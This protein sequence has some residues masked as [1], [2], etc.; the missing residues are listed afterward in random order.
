MS[1]EVQF[2]VYDG[3]PQS[4]T[5]AQTLST[6]SCTLLETDENKGLSLRLRKNGEKLSKLRKRASDFC[7]L[8]ILGEGAY[9]TV[10]LA[11][12]LN[13]GQTQAIKVVQ[14]DFVI[15]H[16]KLAATV[17]EKHVLASLTYERGG[18]PFVT[19]LYCT[20][21]DPERLYF[22][23]DVA[24]HG[25]LMVALNRLGSFDVC[26]CQFYAAE[27][28]AAL[29]FIHKYGVVHRDVKPDNIL[30]RKNGHIMLTDFGSAQVYDESL[31]VDYLEENDS[32]FQIRNLRQFR[33]LTEMPTS[34]N[35]SSSIESDEQLIGSE[36]TRRA[37][38]V[39][40]AQYVSPEMLRGDEVGPPCDYWALGAIVF[41]MISGLA[42]F[43]AINDFHLMNKIQKLDFTFPPNFPDI[44]KDFVS[45]LLVLDPA[46]RLGSSNLNEL[47][48][49]EFFSGIKW[50]HVTDM[51][52]PNISLSVSAG[53]VEAEAT[54]TNA[55][56]PGLNERALNRLMNL[57]LMEVEPSKQPSL[58]SEILNV[59]VDIPSDMVELF[60]MD[61]KAMA[62]R[63]RKLEKQ[64]K[65]NPYHLFVQDN[66]I[67][68]SG[69]IDKK[70]GLFSRRRMFLL[71]EGPHLFY[72]DPNN[73]ELKGEVPW[74][75]CMRTEVKNFRSF[76]VHTPKRIY[77]LFDPESRAVE[78]CKAI[79]QV[80]LR[81]A[82]K[83]AESYARAIKDG[84]FG[85]NKFKKSSN[86]FG[87]KR[88]KSGESDKNGE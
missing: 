41:Q 13:G 22:V 70:K 38:F 26:V 4:S 20:F 66:L 12:E 84:T 76:F 61:K 11:K 86:Y 47:K 71:T 27:I 64:R 72:V 15:R 52:P 17:R 16:Q 8:R 29:E 36:S 39:G 78:W 85:M 68:R 49:H 3:D 30:L 25:E 51:K 34:S 46:T 48:C 5:E 50:E 54:T 58:S 79:E 73:M 28:V 63:Q 23:T 7:F 2:S 82:D 40:T 6:F 55:I 77:Y 74:S 69:F 56:E 10:Y 80:K 62:V 75:P 83:I 57:S 81:Y 59:A 53:I 43:R 31:F 1:V 18:H 19:R 45:K 88:K 65:E 32:L 87:D 37:T 67:I 42:P 9:S 24:H 60:K 35:T 33:K 44:A 21:H 14:K